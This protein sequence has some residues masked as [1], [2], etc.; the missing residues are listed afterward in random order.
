MG[1]KRGHWRW[2][3]HARRDGFAG[4][5]HT[6]IYSHSQAEYLVRAIVAEH[7]GEA[8]AYGPVWEHTP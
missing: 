3:I 8:W 1:A 2:E 6:S 5:V 7:G 4:L